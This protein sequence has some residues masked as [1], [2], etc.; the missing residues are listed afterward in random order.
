M[1]SC[2]PIGTASTGA[3]G[4][5]SS[6]LSRAS[7]IA[8]SAVAQASTFASELSS[9]GNDLPVVQPPTLT[10]LLDSVVFTPY[11][12][13]DVPEFSEYSIAIPSTPPPPSIHTVDTGGL[14]SVSRP[15]GVIPE[16]PD[17]LMPQAPTLVEPEKPGAP[18]SFSDVSIPEYVREPL[19]LVPELFDLDI[20]DAPEVD[21]S[22]FDVVRPDFREPDEYLYDNNLVED[23]TSLA[24]VLRD[25]F[26]GWNPD[27]VKLRDR[28]AEMIESG[29]GLPAEVEQLIFDRAANREEASSQQALM[30]V[31]DEWAERGFSLPGST[32]LAREL[33]I[34]KQNRI[35]KGRV[36]REITIQF[37]TQ[38]IENLRFAVQQGAALEGQR[39]EQF[40]R[41]TDAATSIVDNFYRV[42][43]SLFSVHVEMLQAQIAIYQA[44]IQA[45]RERLQ[46]ELSKL[47][48]FRS[49]LEAARISGEINQQRVQIYQSQL[50]GVLAGV[51]VFRAEVQGANAQIEAQVNQM[52]LYQSRLEAYKADWDGE[53]T[54]FD[55][56]STRVNAEQAKT[57]LYQAQIQAFS[58]RVR[59]YGISVD[60]EAT[61]VNAQTSVNDSETRVYSALTDQWSK[62]VDAEIQTMQA[63]V[64]EYR[65]KIA[66]FSALASAEQSRVE[67]E[68]RNARISFEAAQA[69]VAATLKKV[70]QQIEQIRTAYGIG[71]ESLRGAATVTGQLAGS[72]LSA[73][74]VSA[75]IADQVSTQRAQSSRCS[76]NYNHS[77]EI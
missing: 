16:S 66:A 70:D 57:Q 42:A 72:A 41:T 67:G 40:I 65:G 32:V 74:N 17:I 8:T 37:H 49:Q 5:V 25:K 44:D 10:H 50:Q 77:G 56:Y 31:R 20:P 9:F 33:E 6:M 75:Q 27:S 64:E 4:Q 43:Q 59:A 76:V 48:I 71:L 1:G 54:K 12:M 11:E 2:P 28:W 29:T 61:K 39:F 34:H 47:E 36:N 22:E 3:G 69:E 23:T 63:K 53:R 52:R 30:Q 73:I 46:I 68:S 45:F 60:A 14:D 19:P 13:P 7:N 58:E 24:E 51:E 26:D 38:E 18:P 35:E 21:F 55:I 62:S 15:T